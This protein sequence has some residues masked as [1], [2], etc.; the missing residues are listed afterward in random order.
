MG[1]HHHHDGQTSAERALWIALVLNSIFMFVEVGVGLWSNSLALLSDAGHMVSDVT[2]LAIALV[3]QRLSRVRSVGGFTFG[4]GRVPVLGAFANALSLLA[5][6]GIIFWEAWQRL[7]KQPEIV[8]GAVLWVGLAGLAVNL[9]SALYLHRSCQHSLNIRGVFLHMMADVLGSLGAILAS[10]V[11]MTTGWTPVD[12]WVSMLIATLILASTWPLLRDSVRVLLQS[13]PAHLD[14][15]HIR[16][17]L[18]AHPAVRK[19]E[20]FHLWEVD[21][22]RMI[23]SAYL[24][25]DNGDLAALQD[26][27]DCLR[28]QL[29]EAF[30]ID[31]AT[32][33]WRISTHHLNHC[34]F[35]ES[36]CACHAAGDT[37][38]H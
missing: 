31:H 34:E 3:A 1:Q 25:T 26:I 21:S 16:E 20:D 14:V 2:A 27:S 12:A 6:A 32:F 10:I 7:Q 11:L 38:E 28:K 36:P 29:T 30:G 33:E 24:L 8:A 22:G 18:E 5:I 9:I 19:V 37:H 35:A 4:L 23:L 17:Q 13:A 15:E